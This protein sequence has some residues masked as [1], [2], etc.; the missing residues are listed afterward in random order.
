MLTGAEVRDSPFLRL[1]PPQLSQALCFLLVIP[2]PRN[3]SSLTSVT[4]PRC[5]PPRNKGEVAPWACLLPA[6]GWALSP[7]RYL[8]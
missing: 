2:W 4:P 5:P 3:E 7:G 8:L 1:L 6:Q